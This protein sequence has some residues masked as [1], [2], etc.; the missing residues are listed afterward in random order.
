MLILISIPASAMPRLW[1]LRN[2][3]PRKLKFSAGDAVTVRHFLEAQTGIGVNSS[4]AQPSRPP[5]R[6]QCTRR[7]HAG[8]VDRTVGHIVLRPEHQ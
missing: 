1:M 5:W 3:R 2:R 4:H 6:R 7:G 8:L